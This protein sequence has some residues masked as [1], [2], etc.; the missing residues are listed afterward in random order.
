MPNARAERVGVGLQ[1]LTACG[2]RCDLFTAFLTTLRADFLAGAL[3]FAAG[4]FFAVLRLG[5]FEEVFFAPL[6]FGEV[7]LLTLAFG[8]LVIGA[9]AP[10]PPTV[11]PSLALIGALAP[12][13]NAV[14]PVHSAALLTT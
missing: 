12:F 9:F 3:R 8:E 11:L 2:H 10:D 4:A 1:V 13:S 7:F 14:R 5:V 6:A